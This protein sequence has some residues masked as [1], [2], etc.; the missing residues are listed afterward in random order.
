MR[1][2]ERVA[3]DS[4]GLL[5]LSQTPPALWVK[6]AAS[7]L[8]DEAMSF[9]I[10][11]RPSIEAAVPE[12]GDDVDVTPHP[13][14]DSSLIHRAQ[15]A[16]F[17]ERMR[18]AFGNLDAE[19]DARQKLNKLVQN[20]T[21]ASYV[22][23]FTQLDAQ[24]KAQP[25]SEGDRVE[26]FMNGLKDPIKTHC[27][28]FTACAGAVM[29]FHKLVEVA[30]QLGKTLEGREPSAGRPGGGG[31]KKRG[32]SPARGASRSPSSERGKS[33]RGG[34]GGPPPHKARNNPNG[35]P[36]F[37]NVHPDE[38][39]ARKVRKTCLL[40]DDPKHRHRECDK[41]P[42]GPFGPGGPSA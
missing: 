24:I 12:S 15:W 28:M 40:C 5:T 10:S 13:V 17:K 1:A 9:Y 19:Q 11:V 42:K 41:P 34:G 39:A 3:D 37:K 7:F 38:I 30:L 6:M 4:R 31:G 32:R 2:C 26:K 25:L 22:R 16:A 18:M 14:A 8:R 23:R 35:T 33:G 21:V 27:L 20:G 29:E 36:A